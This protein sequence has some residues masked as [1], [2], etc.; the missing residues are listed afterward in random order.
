M[1]RNRD[2]KIIVQNAKSIEDL[3]SEYSSK[4]VN[5][6]ISL[7]FKD[8]FDELENYQ[9]HNSSQAIKKRIDF[10]MDFTHY[11]ND[12]DADKVKDNFQ[13]LYFRLSEKSSDKK[14]VPGRSKKQAK[15]NYKDLRRLMHTVGELADIVEVFGD[16]NEKQNTFLKEIV[17]EHKNLY[18]LKNTLEYFPESINTTNEDGKPLIYDVICAYLNS[19]ELDINSDDTFFYQ[20]VMDVIMN[21]SRFVFSEKD[22]KECLGEVLKSLIKL[23]VD[24]ENYQDKK[25]ILVDLKEVLSDKKKQKTTLVDIEKKYN[26]QVGFDNHI[27]EMMKA[28]II[29]RQNPKAMLHDYI[30]SIDGE[31]SIELD[32]AFSARV[33]ANGNYLLGVHI[34][35]VTSFFDYNSEIVQQAIA[36]SETIYGVGAINPIFPL[37]YSANYGSLI[38][39]VPKYAESHYFE[40]A[41]DGEIV[42]ESIL[43]TVIVNNKRTTYDK[44]D[45]VIKYG[46]PDLQFNS[47]VKTLVEITNALSKRYNI[48]PYQ[49]GDTSRSFSNEIVLLCNMLH[50]ETVANFFADNKYPIIYRV[51]EQKTDVD[52]GLEQKLRELAIICQ[53]SNSTALL[54]KILHYSQNAQYALS[55]RHEGLGLEH[56]THCSSPLRRGADIVVQRGLDLFY[57]HLGTEREQYKFEDSLP[58]IA[59]NIN[60]QNEKIKRFLSE[61]HRK[62]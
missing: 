45:E 61:C 5:E 33:L 16:K 27:L 49:E 26:I 8:T 24:D 57:H 25:R 41:K 51:Q 31:G 28:R 44:V 22:K 13:E 50:N 2:I 15:R 35:S 4:D 21:N 47:T 18:F 34:A 37:E 43:K 30:I 52:K 23:D 6:M 42:N 58:T 7:L 53:K 56:Y 40:I 38:E 54:N 36:K 48:T 11:N 19:A 62:L 32:D 14:A 3:C 60:K 46:S 17:F 12:V 10:I 55:G 59:H 9:N 20:D 39:G 29:D 1:G